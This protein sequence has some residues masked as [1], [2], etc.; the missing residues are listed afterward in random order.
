M[1]RRGIPLMKYFLCLSPA[2][3][4]KRNTI[5]HD[6]DDQVWQINV[7]PCDVIRVRHSVGVVRFPPPSWPR[8]FRRKK[9]AHF[10][11]IFLWFVMCQLSLW[12][13]LVETAAGPAPP[14][15]SAAACLALRS[16]SPAIPAAIFAAVSTS[17]MSPRGG[18]M[19][20]CRPRFCSKE[21]CLDSLQYS[22]KGLKSRSRWGGRQIRF[23]VC[24]TSSSHAS[25][26]QMVP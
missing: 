18:R 25:G 11:K 6:D 26:K 23:Q 5:F 8:N 22:P 17:P 2:V 7:T 15:A 21:E 3:Q 19:H 20:T 1:L 16:Q 13:R 4:N 10:F 12:R 9:T 14:S 24:S